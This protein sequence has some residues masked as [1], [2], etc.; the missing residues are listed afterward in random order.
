MKDCI[1]CKI[2][3]GE[4]P[5][6]KIWEDENF[7]AFLSIF[8]NTD[9]FSVV[10]PKHHY[11]SLPYEDVEPVLMAQL[12]NAGQKV[13]KKIKKA[14]PGV[15]RVGLI[16]EGLGVNHLHIKLFPMHGVVS[17]EAWEQVSAGLEKTSTFFERY[18]GFISSHDADRADDERLAEIAGKINSVD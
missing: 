9:A 15:G 3:S 7:M 18:P 17:K 11:D 6:F 1:F 14:F 2:V 16:C 13:A 12:V 4:A 8:P 5:S 10:V